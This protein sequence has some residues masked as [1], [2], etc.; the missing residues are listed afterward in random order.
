MSDSPRSGAGET[1]LTGWHYARFRDVA[2]TVGATALSRSSRL[3]WYAETLVL[4][5]RYQ[6][7][8]GASAWARDSRCRPDHVALWEELAKPRLAGRGA[9]ALE[10]GVADG[11]ATR[12]WSHRG[13][14]FAAWHGFDTFEGLPGAW[15]RA[16]VSVMS[17]GV[18]APTAG[19]GSVPSLAA[20]FPYAWHKGLIEET[21]PAFVRPD[22]PLFVLI[23]VDLFE[24]ALVILEWLT[25]NGRPGDLVYFDEA[26]DPWNEGLALRRA[27]EGGLRL[28]AIGHSGSS[29]LAEVASPAA[30]I[31]AGDGP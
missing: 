29:L 4:S 21:L 9:V 24:P 27:F 20:P 1:P 18:F 15:T 17:A 23:D 16:G 28:R 25:Q 14:D 3:L 31:G 12:W 19:A 8:I 7:W 2:L 13:V 22:A 10:F 26:F 5:A 6:Q 30:A 11:R